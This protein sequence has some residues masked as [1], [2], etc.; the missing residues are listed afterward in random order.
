[1][2]IDKNGHEDDQGYPSKTLFCVEPAYIQPSPMVW[3]LLCL[4]GAF[5]QILLY[6]PLNVREILRGVIVVMPMRRFA[7]YMDGLRNIHQLLRD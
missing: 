2:F 6:V 3:V 4:Q 1:M 7:F 5:L